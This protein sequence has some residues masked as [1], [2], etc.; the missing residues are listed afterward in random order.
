MKENRSG[1][2]NGVARGQILNIMEQMF[3]K[4]AQTADIYFVFDENGTQNR[5]PAHTNIL[6]IGSLLFEEMFYGPDK[7][8]ISGDIPTRSATIS[9]TTFDAFITLFYG[10]KL[11]QLQM[12][13]IE[14]SR[15]TNILLSMWNAGKW[16]SI[17]TEN[18]DD[19][20]RLSRNFGAK[21][22]E[23]ACQQF[24]MEYLRDLET[25]E[26]DR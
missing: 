17:T 21:Y 16:K 4:R 23:E 6:S 20:L 3:E 13:Q 24:K 8:F 9:S 1:Y 11:L 2:L 10:K 7:H 5:I 15:M 14:C 18:Y 25:E 19:L 26:I 12:L 22:C